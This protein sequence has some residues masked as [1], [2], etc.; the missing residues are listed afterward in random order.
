MIVAVSSLAR[1]FV[2]TI[3][4]HLRKIFAGI[5]KSISFE[6]SFIGTSLLSWLKILDLGGSEWQ[7]NML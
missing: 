6:R 1:V 5:A 7:W 2:S 3:H 4:F